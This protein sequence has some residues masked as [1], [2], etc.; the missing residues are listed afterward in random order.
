MSFICQKCHKSLAILKALGKLRVLDGYH[1]CSDCHSD[2]EHESVVVRQIHYDRKRKDGTPLPEWLQKELNEKGL[3]KEIPLETVAK[4]VGLRAA[5]RLAYYSSAAGRKRAITPDDFCRGTPEE[6]QAYFK[7]RFAQFTTEGFSPTV[8]TVEQVD[9][10]FQ[11]ISE[12][13][14]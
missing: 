11:K 7:E 5:T 14:S 4:V 1:Q 8:P 12:G 10:A 3:S 9:K 6:A 2:L 13:T